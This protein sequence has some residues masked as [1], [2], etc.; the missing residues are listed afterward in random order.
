M[1]VERVLRGRPRPRFLVLGSW[2][3]VGGLF[4]LR[5]EEAWGVGVGGR[6]PEHSG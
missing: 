5:F 3:V 2:L 1:V 6:S 4:W